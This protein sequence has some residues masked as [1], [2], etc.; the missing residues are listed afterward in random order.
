MTET[1]IRS[2][3]KTISVS[4]EWLKDVQRSLKL[5]NE[6]DAYVALRS[7]LHVLRDR[8][9][10][11]EAVDLGAQLPLLLR[12]VY[13]EGWSLAK[14]PQKTR[15]Q[16][17]FLSKVMQA[18]PPRIELLEKVDTQGIVKG[19][20]GVLEKRVSEGE[21]E[22]IKAVLP[23]GFSSLWPSEKREGDFEASDLELW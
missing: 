19:V 5:K 6:Q 23:K 4:R 17:K 2:L 22:N 14:K 1:N 11:E 20:F 10:P 18:L 8:L 13:Y 12:G 3:D 15:S 21:I 9:T 7:V 16:K